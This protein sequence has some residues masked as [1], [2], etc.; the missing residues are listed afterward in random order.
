MTL[1][2][3]NILQSNSGNNSAD[4][5]TLTPSLSSA[6]TGHAVIVGFASN[7]VNA[8]S[9]PTGFTL[10][11]SGESNV[12]AAGYYVYRKQLSTGETSW[13]FPLSS[14]NGYAWW[15]LEVSGLDSS[16]FVTGIAS[17][18]QAGTSIV[19]GTT[20]S[21][22]QTD[23]MCLACFASN[24]ATTGD[25]WSGYTNSFTEIKDQTTTSGSTNQASVAVAYK[26]P[27]TGGTFT[28]TATPS[29]S[30]NACGLMLVYKAA[31]PPAVS[32]DGVSIGGS[33]GMTGKVTAR[34]GAGTHLNLYTTDTTV[35]GAIVIA[36]GAAPAVTGNMTNSTSTT[37]VS[38]SGQTFTVNQVVQ[39]T[40]TGEVMVVRD[41]WI[42]AGGAEWSN[43]TDRAN[44][45]STSGWTVIGSALIT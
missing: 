15:A 19:T 25:S 29:H 28:S 45:Y 17:S 24:H 8:A 21:T 11:G 44:T 7:N 41:T 22:T 12:G 40:T 39:S 16:P 18:D 6:T 2:V 13:S 43:T 3:G 37:P 20:T 9:P 36:T 42:D 33:F 35:Q 38:T 23:I 27:G 26:F 30:T 34:D 4:E 5:T 1:G 10:D 31:P 32:M 14:S